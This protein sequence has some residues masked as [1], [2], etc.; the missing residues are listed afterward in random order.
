MIYLKSFLAGIAALLISALLVPV[1]WILAQI[2]FYMLYKPEGMFRGEVGWD[3]VSIMRN[4]V[5]P[6]LIILVVFSAG[7]CWEFRRASR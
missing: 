6:W 7:F 3:V 2:L 5:I 4:S 1:G